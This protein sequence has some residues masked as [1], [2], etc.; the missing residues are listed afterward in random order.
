MKKE[1]K[2]TQIE[3][4]LDN[5][6]LSTVEEIS[7]FDKVDRM[8]WIR[9]A[10]DNRIDEIEEEMDDMAIDNYIHSRISEEELKE[11]MDWKTVPPDLKKARA[12]CLKNIVNN[13]NVSQ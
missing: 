11:E 7:E 13:G 3:L 6:V 10:I 12:D 1:S 5:D 4:I 2:T 8:T 9:Q